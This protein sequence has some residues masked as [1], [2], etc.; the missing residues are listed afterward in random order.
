MVRDLKVV[1]GLAT[2]QMWESRNVQLAGYQSTTSFKVVQQTDEYVQLAIGDNSTFLWT[3]LNMHRWDFE[4]PFKPDSVM[5]FGETFHCAAL[6]ACNPRFA[7]NVVI[8]EANCAMGHQ[9][10]NFRLSAASDPN[11]VSFTTSTCVQTQGPPKI[12]LDSCTSII[13]N[14]LSTDLAW[15][16]RLQQ[17]FISGALQCVEHFGREL[18][19]KDCFGVD[20]YE[21]LERPAISVFLRK[22]PT[23]NNPEI[24]VTPKHAQRVFDAARDLGIK[25]LLLFG[26]RVSFIDDLDSDGLKNIDLTQIFR[27]PGFL[28]HFELQL[29]SAQ[30]LLQYWLQDI[31]S[32]TL[33]PHSGGTDHCCFVKSKCIVWTSTDHP[34]HPR[35][36]RSA[37]ACGGWLKLVPVGE[38]KSIPSGLTSEAV[39][40]LKAALRA[41]L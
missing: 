30:C 7:V 2:F 1:D 14:K 35:I 28:K 18:I 37:A 25:T 22:T 19:M 41:W 40:C 34:A 23:R 13:A 24:D 20:T 15:S 17:L 10:Y 6:V 21:V 8:G 11:Q 5:M 16:T 38:M 3:E 12:R 36:P 27:T 33:G 39:A 29:I 26:D 9:Q 32:A 31:V 4:G